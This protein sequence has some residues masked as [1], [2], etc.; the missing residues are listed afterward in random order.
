MAVTAALFVAQ[1]DGGRTCAWCGEAG[2][3]LTVLFGI[4]E[5]GNFDGS[6]LEDGQKPFPIQRVGRALAMLPDGIGGGADL[7]FGLAPHSLRAVRPHR[8]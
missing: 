1:R 5:T 7:V 2:M 4:Y 3:G 6:A 8:C